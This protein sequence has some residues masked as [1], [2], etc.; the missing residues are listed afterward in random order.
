MF[1]NTVKYVL[2]LDKEGI[3]IY[4]LKNKVTKTGRLEFLAETVNNLEFA[5]ADSLEKQ[6]DSFVLNNTI[7]PGNAILVLSEDF[8][9]S[10]SFKSDTELN[11]G[12]QRFLDEI[13]F[14]LDKLMSKVY[15]LP[16]GEI[17]A[18]AT[19]KSTIITLIE[20]FGTKRLRI[21]YAVPE[22]VYK[23]SEVAPA[24]IVNLLK[25]QNFLKR[26]DI[27][28]GNVSKQRLLMWNYLLI[29]FGLLAL[30]ILVLLGSYFLIIRPKSLLTK[31][32]DIKEST[33][34]FV[35][36][37]EITQ[38]SES[39]PTVLEIIREKKD[40]K[41]QVL[42]GTEIRGL[43]SKIKAN[44]EQIGYSNIEV[45]NTE[46]T[47]YTSTVIRHIEDLAIINRDEIN[48]LLK[49]DFTDVT[50]RTFPKNPSETYDITIILG[51]SLR[52]N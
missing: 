32:E 47:G 42:N 40:I 50:I 35:A 18:V 30:I 48:K 5:S 43:A 28:A 3:A 46:T 29:G 25:N 49:E 20:L 1:Y 44:L 7:K 10:K 37:Q 11:S 21:L 14:D 52:N 39:T 41:I 16:E 2:Y 51:D 6:I 9:F 24:V 4:F 45:G 38:T 31:V 34:T 36:L 26:A 15:Y 8:L 17:M 12:Y 13:P 22:L 33:S 27:L 19:I 23:K